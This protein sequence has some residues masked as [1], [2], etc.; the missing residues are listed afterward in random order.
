MKSL[1]FLN[2]GVYTFTFRCEHC[3]HCIPYVSIYCVL[4]SLS[5]KYFLIL[6]VISSLTH[7]LLYLLGFFLQ[8]KSVGY[9]D[10]YP[11]TRGNLLG[12]EPR[13]IVEAEK[14]YDR[15]PASW[16][17]GRPAAQ[18]PASSDAPTAGKPWCNSHWEVEG[19]V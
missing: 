1:L 13:V 17:P 18:L 4:F 9:I 8:T 12:E 11:D 7:W 2:V 5:Q 6:S 16:R 14:S 15:P 19:V 3:V 10:R